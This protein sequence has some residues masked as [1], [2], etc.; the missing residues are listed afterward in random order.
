MPGPFAY[1]QQ[2]QNAGQNG[3]FYYT[4]N[5][6]GNNAWVFPVL[7]LALVILI[8]FLRSEARYRALLEQVA[9]RKGARR[10]H[11]RHLPR[12]MVRRR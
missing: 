3:S 12:K 9:F 10:P 5:S 4:Y 8:A 1:Q 6:I 11:Y 2:F 7:I